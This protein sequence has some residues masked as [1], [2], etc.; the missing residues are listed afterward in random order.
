[1]KAIENISLEDAMIIYNHHVRFIVDKVAPR[2]HTIL[3]DSEKKAMVR[4]Y[5]YENELLPEK[6]IAAIRKE[7]ASQPKS[8][9]F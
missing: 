9:N 7:Q 3:K 2:A 1:M 4:A 6:C 5:L 8:K